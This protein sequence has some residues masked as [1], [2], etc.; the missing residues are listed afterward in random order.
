[1]ELRKVRYVVWDISFQKNTGR[2]FAAKSF[3]PPGGLLMEPYLESHYR[4][5]QQA[6]GMQIME[7]KMDDRAD[8]R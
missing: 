8:S 2:L 4:V 5:L 3:E 7:R 6:G 1:L